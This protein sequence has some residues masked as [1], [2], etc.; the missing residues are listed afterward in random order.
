M[1]WKELQELQE[2]AARLTPEEQLYLVERLVAS[3]RSSQFTNHAGRDRD[4]EAM[5][6]D[7]GVQ[8]ELDAWR[9][10]DVHAAR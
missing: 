10:G 4:L 5:A 7:P 1:N 2:R 3:V 8:G 6:S 9:T